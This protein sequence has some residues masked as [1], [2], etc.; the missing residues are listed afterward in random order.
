VKN[1]STNTTTDSVTSSA[2]YHYL[3]T[4]VDDAGNENIT[5][6]PVGATDNYGNVS[7]TYTAPLTSSGGGGGG[8]GGG[9]IASGVTPA[10]SS[11]FYS[12]IAKGEETIMRV[13]NAALAVTSNVFKVKNQVEAVTVTVQLAEEESV[14]EKVSDVY[15]YF[16]I[17]ASNLE[18][19]DLSSVKIYFAVN[20]SWLS[21]N[22]LDSEKVG[23]LRYKKY[24]Q[25]L[26][27]KKINSS[28]TQHHYYASVPGFSFFAITAEKKKKLLP[29]KNISEEKNVSE[30]QKTAP[31][32][33]SEPKV[34]EEEKSN[35]LRYTAV[36]LSLLVF[37]AAFIFAVKK[38]KEY[39]ESRPPKLKMPPSPFKQ[40]QPLRK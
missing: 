26:I 4:A 15:Q 3:V 11:Y 12:I 25:R 28:K 21:K 22:N 20:K 2:T 7:L 8:G 6:V 33:I 27:T 5:L 23:L 14:P 31:E 29:E 9:G 10:K 16:K 39:M 24:W 18:D 37:A 40:K 34:A 32:T 30:Q 1:V 36:F 38:F 13:N 17:D 35:I 19:K